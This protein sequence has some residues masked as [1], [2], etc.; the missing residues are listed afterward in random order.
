MC[1]LL[2]YPENLSRIILTLTVSPMLY[3]ML[4]TKFSSIQ[5][6]SSPILHC[7]STQAPLQQQPRERVAIVDRRRAAEA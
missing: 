5:G 3:Q 1:D 4:R 2:A 6:S 7:V